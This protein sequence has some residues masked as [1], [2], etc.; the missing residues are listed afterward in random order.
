MQKLSFLITCFIAVLQLSAQSELTQI[1]ACLNDYI[2]GTSYNQVDVISRAF[3]A[4][5]DLF[6]DGREGGLRIVPSAE[7]I[8]WFEKNERDQFNGRVGRIMSVEHFGNIAMA[9]AEIL[10]PKAQ[11]RFIDMF[12]LKKVDNAWKIISKT[13]NSEQSNRMGK[14]ILFVVS[15]AD[16][17]GDTD[18]TTGNSFSEIIEAYDVFDKAGLTIDFVSPEG[19]AVPLAYINTADLMQRDYVYNM[20]FMYA[21]KHT[22]TPAEVDAANYEAIYYVGGGAAMFETPDNA[23]IQQLA[24]DIYEKQEGVVAAICHGTAGIV[25]LKTS[26]GK[27]LVDGKTIS[28]FPESYERQDYDYFKTFPFLIQKT[29]EE[30]G[31]KFVVAPKNTPFMQAQDRVVTGQ[32]HLS[33]KL[34]AEKIL[35]VLKANEM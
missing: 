2:N 33:A 4:E 34:V 24:I 13:A 10:I 30:R 12:I 1:Q 11:K 27:Y 25:H 6:L 9:K 8:S 28:G 19:G 22:Q 17:Y 14:R 23:A 15:N 16:H 26:D 3:H 31:G 5:S 20:D 21:L 29:V 7:Y 35:E 32:N 18:I